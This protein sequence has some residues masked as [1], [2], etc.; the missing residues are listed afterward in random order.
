MQILVE[1]TMFAANANRRQLE[2]RVR[3]LEDC[4]VDGVVMWDHLFVSLEKPRLE[5]PFRPSDP[6]TTLAAVAGL[7]DRLSVQTVVSNTALFHPALLMRQ[8]NQL[9][10]FIG[11]DRVTAGFGAGWNTEEFDALGLPYPKFK[12]RMDRLEDA[13][14]I[15]RQ[16]I[17]QGYADYQ[18]EFL[19]ANE[20][21]VSPMPEVPPRLL[22]GGGSDRVLELA[23]KYCDMLDIHGNPK[24]GKMTGATSTE[25]HLTDTRRRA[26]ATV[27][28]LVDRVALLREI[29]TAAGRPADAVGISLPAWIVTYGDRHE[30]EEAEKRICVEWGHIPPQSLADNPYL[31]FGEPK[32]IAETLHERTERIGQT[33]L[34]LR[35]G[36]MERPDVD[37]VRFGK[38]VI[39]HL[40]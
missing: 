9:A 39:P 14:I 27:E 6:L 16:M 10:V 15:A 32:Q 38:E 23:G 30:I 12:Q 21:P 7:S 33:H 34:I 19:Q 20:L 17:D 11:G 18:G 31:L 35:D 3:Q 5:S 2:E 36:D 40:N 29:T 28:D 37:A 8:F 25:L 13:L 4:G 24:H 26:L 1:L 22:I